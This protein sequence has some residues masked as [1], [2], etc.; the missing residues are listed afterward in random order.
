[1]KTI[2]NRKFDLSSDYGVAKETEQ[3][4]G[5]TDSMDGVEDYSRVIDGLQAQLEHYTP[6]M[7]VSGCSDVIVMSELVWICR[8]GRW[9]R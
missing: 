5:V 2:G 7:E 3:P 8:G 9:R 1:M 4:C 6:S